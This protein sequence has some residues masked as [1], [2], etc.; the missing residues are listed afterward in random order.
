MAVPSDRPHWVC[1]LLALGVLSAVACHK[2]PRNFGAGVVA[3]FALSYF[4]TTE[5]QGHWGCGS[6]VLDDLADGRLPANLALALGVLLIVSEINHKL[7]S[8]ATVIV[9]LVG[10]VLGN[11]IGKKT[12]WNR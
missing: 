1:Q 9:P 12:I 10:A 3:G 4:T 2:S 7:L 6:H 5:D 11:R 8:H